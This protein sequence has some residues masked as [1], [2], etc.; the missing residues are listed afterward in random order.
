MKLLC[1]NNIVGAQC[2]ETYLVDRRKLDQVTDSKKSVIIIGGGFLGSELA[3]C[4]GKKIAM[5]G[6]SVTQVI[7]QSGKFLCDSYNLI[8]SGTI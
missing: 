2:N 6:L 3:S 4:L 5:N 1:L 7:P 8:S